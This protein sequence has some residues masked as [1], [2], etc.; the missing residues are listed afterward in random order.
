MKKHIIKVCIKCNL[1]GEALLFRTD[2]NICKNCRNRI[3]REK[4]AL[5]PKIKKQIK[6]HFICKCCKI[7]GDYTIFKFS[8]STCWK[9]ILFKKS[10]NY[11]NN[12]SLRLKKKEYDL[13]NKEHRNIVARE[14][15]KKNNDKGK[16][17]AKK[18]KEE[19][20][21]EF[22][23]LQALYSKNWRKNN[24]EKYKKIQNKGYLKRSLG[25]EIV[26]DQLLNLQSILIK[27]KKIKNEI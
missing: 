10:E 9:C 22:L 23:K 18:R 14:W 24:P 25:L 26:P 3:L 12:E 2:R 20:S 1:K 7:E 5:K 16:N 13:K 6:T 4:R 17:Y 21:E 27:I 15:Y 8:K 11:K 19:N